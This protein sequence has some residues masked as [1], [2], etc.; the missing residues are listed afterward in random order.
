VVFTKPADSIA[1]PFDDIY[2]HPEARSQLDY[3]GELCFIFGRDCKDVREEEALDC[4][5]G[6]TIGNDIS[7]RNYIPQEISGFQMSYGKS[8]DAFAPFGP[9]IVSPAVVGNPHDLRLV[10]RVN[11]EVRQDESTAD[12]I[13]NIPQIIVHL[14][15]GRTVRAGTVCMTGTPSGVGWFMKPPGYVGDQDVVEVQIEK[16]GSLVNKIVFS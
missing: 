9:F 8:F 12:M 13:W 1:G 5:L 10:T 2:C 3:E 4:V 16:L 15:R 14:T 7:A 6:Y 11:G